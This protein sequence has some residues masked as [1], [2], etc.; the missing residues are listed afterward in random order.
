VPNFFIVST[1]DDIAPILTLS[2]KPYEETKRAVDKFTN[3]YFHFIHSV[4]ALPPNTRF[5][6]VVQLKLCAVVRPFDLI[7]HCRTAL[8][9]ALDRG[10]IEQALV[11]L[12]TCVDYLDKKRVQL[13]GR[14]KQDL[15]DAE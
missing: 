15:E 6:D 8:G 7:E 11:E 3:V 13:E 1:H 2:Q 14:T 10:P 9:D 5:P 4:E 12:Q